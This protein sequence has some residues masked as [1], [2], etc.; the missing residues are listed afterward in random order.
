MNAGWGRWLFSA[1][2]VP[3]IAY[4]MGY[5]MTITQVPPAQA[6]RA[7]LWRCLAAFVALTLLSMVVL[8]PKGLDMRVTAGMLATIGAFYAAVHNG[9]TYLR[10]YG[11][12]KAVCL[13]GIEQKRIA[14]RIMEV[15]RA[16]TAPKS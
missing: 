8:S 5:I 14:D 2:V 13:T 16:S 4:S 6:S 11:G 1:V 9:F 7:N 3:V 10:K 12:G 15:R